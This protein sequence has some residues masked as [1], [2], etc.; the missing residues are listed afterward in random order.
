MNFRATNLNHQLS[1][2]RGVLRWRFARTPL[3][4]S[5]FHGSYIVGQAWG[6]TIGSAIL[7][8][9]VEYVWKRLTTSVFV[10]RFILV[11]VIARAATFVP[12]KFEILSVIQSNSMTLSQSGPHCDHGVCWQLQLPFQLRLCFGKHWNMMMLIPIIIFLHDVDAG[13]PSWWCWWLWLWCCLRSENRHH[14]PTVRIGEYHQ[15]LVQP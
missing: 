5:S 13:C 4:S 1:H 8:L 3:R 7:I 12:C 9:Q 11:H 6:S 2:H 14:L 10:P 15:P